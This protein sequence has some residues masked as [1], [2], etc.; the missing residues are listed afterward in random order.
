MIRAARRPVVA[1]LPLV[2]VGGQL[3]GCG[4]KPADPQSTIS[5]TAVAPSAV[6]P[7][8]VAP[9]AVAPSAVAPSAVAPSADV[10]S[11]EF[12]ELE[13]RF[14]A[15]LGV[16]AVD[17][18][19]G[20]T[21]S[22]RGNERFAYASTFKALLAAVL[23][24]RLSDAELRRVV[25]YTEADLLEHAPITSKHVATGMPV[26]ALIAAAVQYSDNTAANLLLAEI[27]GPK[28]LQRELRK[29]NDNTT[30]VSRTEP[31]LNGA[32]PGDKRDT[33]TPRAL[34]A[35]LRK[36]VLGDVLPG[37]RRQKLADLL[38]GNTTGGPYIRT[39]VPAGW[40]VGDKTGAGGYGTRND[41]AVVWP[42][43]GSPLVIAVQSDRGM[44]DA[45]SADSLI[46]EATKV[47]IA[48]LR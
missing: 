41:I 3:T 21:V 20:R 24:R 35:D 44:P 12:G 1:V 10:V 19:T 5:H 16:Y 6:A 32:T 48:A 39:G 29:I 28:G 26:E 31:T 33:S 7:S 36:V 43:T 13:R 9:S 11:R 14:G 47:V 25:H 45:P 18:G 23:L 30:V 4:P 34:G 46:A 8:A 27:G 40:K 2:L 42:P 38:I 15:R 17:T 37:P 22:H